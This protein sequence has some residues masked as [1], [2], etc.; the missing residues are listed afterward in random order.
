M[1]RRKSARGP[2]RRRND[3]ARTSR[4]TAASTWCSSKGAR[5]TAIT[6]EAQVVELT[7]SAARELGIDFSPTGSVAQGT[8][9]FR[10]LQTPQGSVTLTAN[11]YAQVQKGKGHILAKPRI[12]T[13]SGIPASIIT[14]DALPIITSISLPGGGGG[15]VQQQVQYINVGVNLQILP[16]YNGGTSVTARLYA[17]VSSVTAYVQGVPQISQREATTTAS[18]ESG[19]ALV[20]GGLL[21]QN[22]LNNLYAVPGISRL[23]IIGGLFKLARETHQTTNLYVILTP[24]LTGIDDP[25]DR[26]RDP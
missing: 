18:L 23:P 10:S 19:V 17:A 1:R 13:L 20:I 5:K 15:I 8:V 7:D 2:K 25:P 12:A 9:N 16:R 22:D 11:L 24:Y 26:H 4:S 3:S 14:G 6:L 21:Q